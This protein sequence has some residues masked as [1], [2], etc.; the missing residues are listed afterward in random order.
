MTAHL[1]EDMVTIPLG[2]AA[3]PEEVATFIVF[4]A[5]DE[6]S[7]STGSEFIMDGGL[8]TAVPNKA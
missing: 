3:E 8:V 6:S 4:L 2:R 7:Y 5:S 1:P